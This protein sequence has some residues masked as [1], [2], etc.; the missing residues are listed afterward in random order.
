MKILRNFHS[1]FH[2]IF[3]GKKFSIKNFLKE[4]VANLKR[5]LS[6]FDRC[7]AD[8]QQL[9]NVSE[10]LR[11]EN[12]ELHQIMDQNS[13]DENQNSIRV[14]L[15]QALDRITALN[16]ENMELRR[17]LDA[18]NSGNASNGS[19]GIGN[20]SNGIGNGSNGSI[21]SPGDDRSSVCS[22]HFDQKEQN[23][24]KSSKFFIF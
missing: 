21:G 15:R 7:Q 24:K 3:S 6:D 9:R 12:A 5:K 8:L 19:N 20:S 1:N 10:H 11:R 14:E 4:E 18:A 16:G 2:S 23:R 17:L 22:E 13:E